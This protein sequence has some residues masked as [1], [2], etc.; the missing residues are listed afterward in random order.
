MAEIAQQ[1]FVASLWCAEVLARLPDLVDG[2]LTEPDRALVLA[3]V[4]GCTWCERFGGSYGRVV[5][6][7]KGVADESAP[8]DVAARLDALL[9]P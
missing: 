6:S 2:T 9:D 7:L 1:R 3:H 5:G 8:A 4:A